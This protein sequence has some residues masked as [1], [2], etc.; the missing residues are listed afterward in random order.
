MEPV[1][2]CAARLRASHRA[3]TLLATPTHFSERAGPAFFRER[4]PAG[5]IQVIE[6]ETWDAL[7]YSDVCVA[8]S[9]TV[10]VEA[11]LLGAPMVTFYRVSPL[12]WT[13]GRHLV[14]APFLTMVNLIAGRQIVPELM[15]HEATGERLATEAALL[16]DDEGAR[17]RMKRDIAQVSSLLATEEHPMDRAAQ[18]A[19]E[20]L[21]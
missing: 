21:S 18:I 13:L 3:Q 11:A 15:Q 8:A 6:G 7:A 12:S 4:I 2:D 19:L 14:R 20:F 9:G 5:T 1:V 17:D 16:L 10:T